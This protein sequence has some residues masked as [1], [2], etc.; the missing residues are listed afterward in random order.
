[1]VRVRGLWL[2]HG[3]ISYTFSFLVELQSTMYLQYNVAFT[4]QININIDVSLDLF[5]QSPDNGET[6]TFIT[7]SHL[8]QV[9]LSGYIY[10]LCS[11]QL[12]FILN[13]LS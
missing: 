1:M 4:C 3:I 7:A 8:E 9:F 6:N 2:T 11:D 13:T 10:E 12:H 5:T